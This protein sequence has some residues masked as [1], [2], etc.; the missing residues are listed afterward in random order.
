MKVTFFT[1]F[2]NHYQSNLADCF[3]ERLGDDFTF[4]ATEPIDESF[5]GYLSSDYSDKKYLLNSYMNEDNFQKAVELGLSSDIV[6]I[7]SAPDLFIKKRLELDK[8][9]FRYNERWLKKGD[10]QVLSP[11]SWWYVYNSHIKYRNNKYYMLSA[12]AYTASDVNL[13][14]SY[15]N[16]CYKWGYFPNVEKLNINT[17][18]ESKQEKKIKLFWVARWIDWKHPE[19]AVELAVQLKKKGYDFVLEMAGDGEMKDEILKLIEQNDVSENIQVLGNIQNDYILQ[20]MRESNAFILTS[21]RGEGW[22]VVVNE[23]MSNGCT[24]VAS[25]E[26]GSIPFLIQNEVNG[27][28]F[29]SK[30]LNSLVSQV[31]KL[32]NDREFCNN[33]ARN[34]YNTMV[35]IW[36]PKNAVNNFIQLAKSLISDETNSIKEGPCS[37]AEV[38]TEKKFLKKSLKKGL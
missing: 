30:K 19:L 31:E 26:I 16:K 7:G 6:I 23:A 14:F 18:L 12:S 13:F 17:I 34:A 28:V 38:I 27:L 24:V 11:R 15:P 35:E 21:D 3:Y 37:I 9:V 22:G 1:N 29:E 33:L 20:K 10:Y 8:I 5:K 4:V 32:I 36:N 25:H 2:I